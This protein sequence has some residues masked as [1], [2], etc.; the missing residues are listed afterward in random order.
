[1]F[2]LTV[3]KKLYILIYRRLVYMY[4]GVLIRDIKAPPSWGCKSGYE[5]ESKR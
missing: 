5:K 4:E 3:F 2:W 1:M